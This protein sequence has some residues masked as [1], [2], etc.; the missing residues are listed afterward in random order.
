[1][2]HRRALRDGRS[3]EKMDSTGNREKTN[4]NNVNKTNK[5]Y[6]APRDKFIPTQ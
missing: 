2:K 3:K 5:L 4:N 6:T 1:M